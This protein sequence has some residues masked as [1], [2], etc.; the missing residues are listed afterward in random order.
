M[1]LRATDAK[2]VGFCNLDLWKTLHPWFL[3]NWSY[4]SLS[5]NFWCVLLEIIRFK[6]EGPFQPMG[7]GL[8]EVSFQD[9]LFNYSSTAGL[10]MRRRWKRS[11][12][13][14]LWQWNPVHPKSS[15]VTRLDF[16]LKLYHLLG[17]LP[18]AAITGYDC[19]FDTLKLA[20]ENIRN[21]H[22]HWLPLYSFWLW[23]GCTFHLLSYYYS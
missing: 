12:A 8:S 7:H 11:L 16:L 21:H 18:Q 5:T 22:F 1:L 2:K 15:K 4:P 20:T 6:M 14:C 13:P 17:N 3:I 23:P 10:N 19:S 9:R